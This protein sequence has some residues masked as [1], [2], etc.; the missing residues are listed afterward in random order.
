MGL[1]VPLGMAFVAGA[2]LSVQAFLNGRLGVSIGSGELAALVNNMVGLAA[3]LVCAGASGALRRAVRRLRDGDKGRPWHYATSGIGAFFVIVAAIAAPKVGIALLTVAVVCGQAFGSV[4][5]DALGLSPAGRRGPTSARVLGVALA[6][7]AVGIA[8]LGRGRG[9]DLGLLALAMA[10]GAGLAVG[11]AGLGQ[12]TV[13]S[14]EP[15]AAATVGFSLGAVCTTVAVVVALGA[16]SPPHG[17]SAPVEQWAGGLFGAAV[18]VG[19][20]RLVITLGVLRLTLALV[21]GQSVGALV[22]DLAAPAAGR[23]VTI[24]TVISVLL[25]FAAVA[26]SGMSLQRTSRSPSRPTR[27]T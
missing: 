8:A 11:Q 4:V 22:L 13:R 18:V 21:A 16:V 25:T 23:E 20:G 1:P 14:G 12:L 9:L 3:L 2:G 10:S 17:W 27:A 19:L 6:L 5:A 7:V 15:L 26:V 24:R